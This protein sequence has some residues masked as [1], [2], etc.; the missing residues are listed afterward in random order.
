MG[1][2]RDLDLFWAGA[3]VYVGSYAVFLSFDYRLIFLLLTVPQLLRWT[4][5]RYG[6][7][8]VTVA[9]LL[10]A[11]W[12]DVWTRMPGLGRVLTWWARTTAVGTAPPLTVAVIAQYVLFVTLVAWLLAT[13][14]RGLRDVVRR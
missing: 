6:T 7:A 4:R 10:V 2:I 8:Y 12:L 3:C 9:A 11:M 5:A 13:F 1:E 14:P